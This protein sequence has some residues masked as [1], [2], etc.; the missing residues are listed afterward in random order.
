MQGLKL[1]RRAL[2]LSA[3]ALMGCSSKPQDWA[4]TN[5]SGLLPD[6]NFT[7]T[8][9]QDRPVTA[10]NYQGDVVMLYFGY[11]H[12][13]DVCPTTMARMAAVMQALGS[14]ANDVRMIFV[15]VDPAR[16]T[17][18]LL[19]TYVHA[20]NRHAVGLTG[21]ESAIVDVARRYRVAYED[22]KP[23]ASGN[24]AVTHSSAIYIFDKSGRAR[25]LAASNN[26]VAQITH[27]VRRLL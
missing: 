22:E 3:V 27:D 10:K 11:T 7:L 23:D 2:L 8:S 24:Y 4:L 21:S 25:L 19:H 14:Q 13:P 1:A 16:D 26:T 12:C 17:P 15:S 20:F 5:I 9:D 18:S 6:L